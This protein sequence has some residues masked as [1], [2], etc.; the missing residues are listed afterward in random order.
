MENLGRDNA[1]YYRTRGGPISDAP[2]CQS[3]Q[4]RWAVI[5]GT[6]QAAIG[7][8]VVEAETAE[9][10]RDKVE[11]KGYIVMEVNRDN[12]NQRVTF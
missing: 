11:R 2:E 9:L 3:H 4:V 6:G 12:S 7:R 10:A 1:F 5:V 8:V